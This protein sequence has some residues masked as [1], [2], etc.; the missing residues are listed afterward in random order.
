MTVFG[1]QPYSFYPNPIPGLRRE[2]GQQTKRPR[3]ESQRSHYVTS[4]SSSPNEM[5][6]VRFTFSEDL[7]FRPCDFYQYG[8]VDSTCS[9]ACIFRYGCRPNSEWGALRIIQSR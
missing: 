1:L 3:Q 5:R 8:K 7:S 9:R 2:T 4:E 6:L